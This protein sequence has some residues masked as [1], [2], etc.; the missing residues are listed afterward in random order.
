MGYYGRSIVFF[1]TL[2]PWLL[3]LFQ[4]TALGQGGKVT[5]CATVDAQSGTLHVP[6]LRF[7]DSLYTMDFLITGSG[8]NL[9]SYAIA[10]RD[11][12]VYY[13]SN[14]SLTTSTLRIPCLTFGSKNYWADLE[15]AGVNGFNLQLRD[16]GTAFSLPLLYNAGVTPLQGNTSTFFT[17]YVSYYDQSGVPPLSNSVIIDGFSHP[18][19]LMQG[20]ASN[21]T[22]SVSTYLFSGNHSFEVLFT[23]GR[24]GKAVLLHYSGLPKVTVGGNSPPSLLGGALSPVYGME[25]SLFSFSVSYIDGYGDPPVSGKMILRDTSAYPMSL[26]SGPA[27]DGVYGEDIPLTRGCYC[28]RFEYANRWGSSSLPSFG[29]FYGPT[30]DFLERTFS[31]PTIVHSKCT[32]NVNPELFN[33]SVSPASG[34]QCTKFTFE[35]DY[36]DFD[37]NAPSGGISVYIDGTPYGMSLK[38]GIPSNGT[39]STILSLPPNSHTFYFYASDGRCGTVRYPPIGGKEGP[40]VVAVLFSPGGFSCPNPGPG[41]A[42]PPTNPGDCDPN[43]LDCGI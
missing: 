32:T 12:S 30:V 9:V 11:D 39:Y 29:N 6:C 34:D 37:G 24:Y 35:V 10:K 27:S 3:P 1:F 22:Y 28:Y 2:L 4:S 26:K 8:L 16:F 7:Q 15:R 5:Q 17:F 13:C 25:N 21:G 40:S 19:T 31:P 41:P 20:D 43:V 36:F 42:V 33:G 18:L 38:S 14:Y 23:D